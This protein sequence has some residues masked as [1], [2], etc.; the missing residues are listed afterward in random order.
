MLIEGP[1][2]ETVVHSKNTDDLVSHPQGNI[3]DRLYEETS[4]DLDRP[5]FHRRLTQDWLTAMEHFSNDRIA[6]SQL[7]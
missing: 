6:N 3:D 1:G 4:L 7:L 5:G 2:S